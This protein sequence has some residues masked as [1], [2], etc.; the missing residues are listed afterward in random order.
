MKKVLCVYASNNLLTQKCHKLWHF[1]VFLQLS[2]KIRFMVMVY[3]IKK[4]LQIKI[5]VLH[6]ILCILLN[7]S[8]YS[9]QTCKYLT[10]VFDCII[11]W[12]YV[13]FLLQFVNVFYNQNHFYTK[14][15]LVHLWLTF[16]FTGNKL[17]MKYVVFLV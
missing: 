12:Q 8:F 15:L 4:G 10:K 13:K 16:L 11:S 5:S 2:M 1:V 6:I 14:I 7:K 3:V 17:W 9:L